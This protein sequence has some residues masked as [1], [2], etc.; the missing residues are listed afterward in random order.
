MKG[1]MTIAIKLIK[2]S[3]NC[4][5]NIRKSFKRVLYFKKY[6]NMYLFI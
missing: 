5:Y 1:R 2:K 6:Q 3:N 4:D